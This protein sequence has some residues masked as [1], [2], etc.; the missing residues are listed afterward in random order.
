M[1]NRHKYLS[2]GVTIDRLVSN[3]LLFFVYVNVFMQ[4]VTVF[5][6]FLI[7]PIKFPNIFANAQDK[8]R[9]DSNKTTTNV[10]H[11]TTM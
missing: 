10:T 11:T 6:H 7:R 8:I 5:T 1:F 4:N 3:L 9:F 2:G